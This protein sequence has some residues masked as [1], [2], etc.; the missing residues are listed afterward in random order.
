M[1][2]PGVPSVEVFLLCLLSVCFLSLCFADM[3]AITGIADAG[4]LG[5]GQRP[6]LMAHSSTSS[7]SPFWHMG[8]TNNRD[9]GFS[10]A[11]SL[12]ETLGS[13][14]FLLFLFACPVLF[15]STSLLFSSCRDGVQVCI[16]QIPGLERIQW[17][18][19][20]RAA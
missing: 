17:P 12:R 4:T 16:N 19:S 8:K 13:R 6:C 5:A 20:L 9:D 11:L 15:S 2:A 7:F 3:G 10:V 1:L 18:A 14:L